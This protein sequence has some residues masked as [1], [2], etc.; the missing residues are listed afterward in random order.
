MINKLQCCTYKHRPRA[1]GVWPQP[2]SRRVLMPLRFSEKSPEKPYYNNNVNNNNNLGTRAFPP[3]NK[4]YGV[5][6]R[7]KY[8]TRP[9]VFNY[10]WRDNGL[11]YDFLRFFP[12]LFIYFF[13]FYRSRARLFGGKTNTLTAGRKIII[14]RVTVIFLHNV[15]RG[16]YARTIR[17]QILSV[18]APYTRSFFF[19]FTYTHTARRILIE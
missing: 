6:T 5:P 12:V 17:T 3:Y 1:Y 16:Y 8:G 4:N 18:L 14:S 2:R 9:G 19:F 13:F 10:V 11:Y 15:I 7:I